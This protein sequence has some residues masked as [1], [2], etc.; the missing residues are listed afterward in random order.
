MSF[1][2]EFITRELVSDNDTPYKKFAL[3]LHTKKALESF[4]EEYDLSLIFNEI[5]LN[6]WLICSYREDDRFRKALV[7]T[8]EPIEE[9]IEYHIDFIIRWSNELDWARKIIN[10]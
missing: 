3:F 9:F 2:D 4:K 8:I 6:T 10:K 7:D 1:K 5:P